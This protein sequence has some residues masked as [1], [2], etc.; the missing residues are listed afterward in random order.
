[1]PNAVFLLVRSVGQAVR[2]A[3]RRDGDVNGSEKSARRAARAVRL[4]RSRPLRF[5]SVVSLARSPFARRH[6]SH[7]GTRTAVRPL[8]SFGYTYSYS[9][10]VYRL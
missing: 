8:F 7:A 10:I 4:F 9:C 3:V 1:M 2:R 5:D 6:T